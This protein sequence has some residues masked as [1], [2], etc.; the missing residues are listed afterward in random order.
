MEQALNRAQT[1]PSRTEKYW[2]RL[3]AAISP[4]PSVPTP[5]PAPETTEAAASSLSPDGMP[6]ATAAAAD[7]SPSPED[8]N[9]RTPEP[10][11]PD[12]EENRSGTSL[13]GIDDPHPAVPRA[14]SP[15]PTPEGTAPALAA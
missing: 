7:A 11:D 2:D 4:P 3:L 5:D 10:L 8:L 6:L 14:C 9:P 13:P 12:Q 15:I 1:G